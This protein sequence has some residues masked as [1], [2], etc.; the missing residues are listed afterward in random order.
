MSTDL[1]RV[2]IVVDKYFEKDSLRGLSKKM[3]VWLLGSE[4]NRTHANDILS[5]DPFDG[6]DLL[7]GGITIFYPPSAGLSPLSLLEFIL[8]E[9]DEHHNEYSHTPGWS[10]AH[11][12][13]VKLDSYLEGLFKEF[14]FSRFKVLGDQI[15]VASK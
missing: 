8:D 6:E 7:A 13:G 2:G 12:Y 4:I 10:E 14:G 3:H 15:F 9:I 5:L 11:V 1:H